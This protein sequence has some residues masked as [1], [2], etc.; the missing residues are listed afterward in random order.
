MGYTSDDMRVELDKLG[1]PP[2]A[3][4]EALDVA[5]KLMANVP[6]DQIG[7]VFW[8]LVHRFALMLSPWW[9]EF[10]KSDVCFGD[11]ARAWNERVGK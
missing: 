9:R 8:H 10:F 5:C 4:K 1:F 6:L 3:R 7:T 2:E 11:I